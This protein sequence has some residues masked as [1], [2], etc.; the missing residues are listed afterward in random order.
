MDIA[1]Y[2]SERAVVNAQNEASVKVFQ[3][4][5]KQQ[6]AVLN[7]L[8]SGIEQVTPRAPEQTGQIL[9]IQA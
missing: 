1:Q 5:R 9:N 3:G 2:A 7:I 4:A 6:E 8:L